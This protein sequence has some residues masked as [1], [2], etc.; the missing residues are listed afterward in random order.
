VSARPYPAP[1]SG[2]EPRVALVHDFF[3]QDGGAERCAIEFARLLPRADVRTSF[4][5]TGRFGD[6]IDPRRVR[7]WPIQRLVGPT[8]RFRSLLPLYP[9][10]FG[11]LDLTDYDIVLSSSVAF[12]KAV[13][14]RTDACHVSYVYTPIRYAWDLDTYLSNSSLPLPARLAAKA[15]RSSLRRWDM[16]TRLRPDRLVAISYTVRD[17]IERLWRR[18]AEVIYP[19]VDTSDFQLGDRDDGYYVIASRLLSYRRVDV[20]VRACTDLGRELV[21]IGEGPER[22]RLEALAGPSVRFA[23]RV[24]RA[25]LIKIVRRSHAYL[26]PGIEDFGI[27]PVEAMAAGKPVIA[28]RGGGLRETVIHG[29]TGILYDGSDPGALAKAISEADHGQFKP[30]RVRERAL[31]FDRSVFLRRW[32]DLLEGVG[33]G[34]SLSVEATLDASSDAVSSAVSPEG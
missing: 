1:A 5:D 16:R 26:V 22:K 34:S 11:G 29:E 17:R 31:E 27:A 18:D 24:A 25:E 4:F 30:H 19:P 32:R 10:Y 2:R 14:T 8:E 33:A 3:I 6:R 28:R 9:L 7:V 21:V 23:G 12:S 15:V 13:R 20:A